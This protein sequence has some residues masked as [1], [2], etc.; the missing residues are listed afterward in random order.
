MILDEL[1]KAG[2]LP[3][4][5]DLMLQGRSKGVAALLAF[6]SVLSIR[7]QY[8][9]EADA[10]LGQCGNVAI[11][12]LREPETRKWAS[13]LFGEYEGI[14]EMRS[15]T[16]RGTNNNVTYTK[17]RFKRSTVLDSEFLS[18]TRPKDT[19]CLDAYY[20][21]AGVGAYHRKFRIGK[22]I[23]PPAPGPAVVPRPAED[24]VLREKLTER[25]IDELGI[26]PYL[27]RQQESQRTR[28]QRRTQRTRQ[29]RQADD[30]LRHIR[31]QTR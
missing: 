18:L 23:L 2:K 8:Q 25:E 21:T 16:T 22:S 3:Y 9:A 6:Q 11:F 5:D 15:R 19:G 31:R 30:S 26:R 1:G 29:T 20:F 10:L 28:Q 27:D 14:E 13:Q 12:Q 4:L 7:A 17:Q 24:F